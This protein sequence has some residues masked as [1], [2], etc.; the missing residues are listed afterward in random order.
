MKWLILAEAFAAVCA[1]QCMLRADV[2]TTC[3]TFVR[4]GLAENL[5]AFLALNLLL[6]AETLSAMLAI[7]YMEPQ[8]FRAELLLADGA[9]A[10]V[11][12]T[13]NLIGAI[14]TMASAPW[15]HQGSAGRTFQRFLLDAY[16]FTTVRASSPVFLTDRP[17]ANDAGVEVLVAE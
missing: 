1:P 10:D 6:Q 8:M 12:F 4:I 15:A 2:A 7:F 14:V 5:A 9:F 16:D 13:V 17:V 3:R 11:L